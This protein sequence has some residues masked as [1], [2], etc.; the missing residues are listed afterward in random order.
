[1]RGEEEMEL[2]TLDAFFQLD[3]VF[4]DS[5]V[6]STD[7]KPDVFKYREEEY[8]AIAQMF[9]A[10]YQIESHGF[11]YGPPGTGKTHLV[12]RMIESFNLYT[13]PKHFK[14]K[15]D[16]P[17]RFIMINCKKS[18]LPQILNDTLVALGGKERSNNQIGETERQIARFVKESNVCLIFDEADKITPTKTFLMPLEHIVGLFT[19]FHEKHHT[20]TVSCILISNNPRLCDGLEESTKSSFTA[21]HIKFKEYD[22]QQLYEI[23]TE[24]CALGFQPNIISDRDLYDFAQMIKNG[25]YDLRDSFKALNC[26]GLDAKKTSVYTISLSNLKK[27]LKAIEMEMVAEAIKDLDMTNFAVYYI[28]GNLQLK[29]QI[30]AETMRESVLVAHQEVREIQKTDLYRGY[31]A[32]NRAH[33]IDFPL[34]NEDY[35]AYVSAK[36]MQKQGFLKIITHGKGKGRST[37]N[38]YELTSRTDSTE[39][40]T[41]QELEIINNALKVEMIRRVEGGM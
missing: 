5:N 37:Y 32:L 38:T 28:I 14:K 2:K 18:T 8:N 23:L 6:F 20:P 15:N 19:R 7:W 3:P 9:A 13:P 34:H 40:V 12:Q 17:I 33:P 39:S 41:T 31:Q 25:S 27:S 11:I 10:H 4:K 29:K 22:V 16:K 35:L 36:K 1:M 30:R 26:A 21:V 24:R